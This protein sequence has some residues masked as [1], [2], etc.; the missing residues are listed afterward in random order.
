MAID[1]TRPNTDDWGAVL[2]RAAELTSVEHTSAYGVAVES[3]LDDIRS[4]AAKGR[5]LAPVLRAASR[6]GCTTDQI[7]GALEE[8]RGDGVQAPPL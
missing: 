4:A 8:V 6:A 3:A 1:T 2:G 5:A 7:L